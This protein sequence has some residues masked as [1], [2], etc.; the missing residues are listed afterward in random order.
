MGGG[1]CKG[2]KGGHA[3]WSD[4][5]DDGEF[6]AEVMQADLGDLHVIDGDVARRC[7]EQAK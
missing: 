5:R 1:G 7:L 2:G 6:G 3:G 4:L